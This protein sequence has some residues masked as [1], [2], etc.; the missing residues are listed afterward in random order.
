MCWLLFSIPLSILLLSLSGSHL[1]SSLHNNGPRESDK[2]HMESQYP[3]EAAVARLY[4]KSTALTVSSILL[5]V[6]MCK[7]DKCL[8]CPRYK[9]DP[10]VF[11][12]LE[13]CFDVNNES[14]IVIVCR[15]YIELLV[16]RLENQQGT[17]GSLTNLLG[18]YKQ[19]MF[20][21]R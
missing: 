9:Y 15:K 1:S 8:N 19:N 20:C 6:Y 4:K 12:I 18:L 11:N 2:L 21:K 3:S 13:V 14:N 5:L 17:G 16:G 7:L 10:N